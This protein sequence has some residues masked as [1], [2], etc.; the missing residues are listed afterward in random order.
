MIRRL[1]CLVTLAFA[2]ARAEESLA[3]LTIV[4][5][6]QNVAESREL[7]Q[8]YA[9]KRG[10][11]RD[12]LVPLGCSSSEEI[13]REEYDAT[14]RDPLRKTLADRGWWKID[15]GAEHPRV[16]TTQVRFVALIKGVPLKIRAAVG[17][18]GDQPG[19]GPVGNRNE[20]S[21][22]SEL[23]ALGSFSSQISGVQNNRYFQSYRRVREFEDASL[24]LV[25]RLD[26]ADAATVRRMI[27]DAVETERAGLWGRA[28]VDGAHNTSGGFEIGDRWMSEVVSQMHKAG[29]PVVFD[30]KPAIF[31]EGFPIT[32][33][34]LYYGWYAG[35]VS[36]AFRDPQFRFERGAVAV[37]I[38]SFSADT[39][40]NPNAHWSAPLLARGAA[41]TVGNVFEP[42]LQLTAH[43]DI[44]NDRL[45]HGFSLAEAAWIATPGLSWVTVVLGDPLY[46]PYAAWLQLDGKADTEWHAYHD[47][48]L[49]NGN[50][51][52]AEYRSLGRQFASR[53]R[54]GPMIEDL[55]LME[56]RDGNYAAAVS[57][58]SQAR[59]LYSARDDILR[60]VLEE[61]EAWLAQS[62]PRRALDLVRSVSRIVAD[63]PS[64][65]L[66]KH[67][68]QEALG[69]LSNAPP[70][71]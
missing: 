14:I 65:P 21:V 36:G 13:S 67:I 56:A 63:A 31:P 6:N 33:C 62:K 2:S 37:H 5:F 48:A 58:F 22:D 46:R 70:R 8:F 49:K 54:N 28:F 27:V 52:A 44:L 29:V 43:L 61:S 20:A 42:Y 55:G 12:H 38:H 40:R 35:D 71:R 45:L 30:D 51:P 25:S 24:L 7:A 32:R 26:A 53:T 9:Q 60:V 57:Y 16:T 69:A 4:I 64:A 18:A 50:K 47:F 66:L 10:I 34:G 19:Q 15:Q 68:E 11:A 59:T 23:T 1:F 39:L 3:P 41:A 17:Y